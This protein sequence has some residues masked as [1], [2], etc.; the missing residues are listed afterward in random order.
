VDGRCDHHLGCSFSGYSVVC[1]LPVGICWTRDLSQNSEFVLRQNQISLKSS[2]TGLLIL[3]V[4]F[5]FFLVFVTWVYPIKDVNVDPDSASAKSTANKGAAV[6]DS[7]LLGGI[8]PPPSTTPGQPA[9]KLAPN[10]TGTSEADD[11]GSLPNPGKSSP[12]QAVSTK[13]HNSKTHSPHSP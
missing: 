13:C 4:S 5:A 9:Q 6:V 8:G 1:V 12:L 7:R 10:L 11:G 3:T 2:V